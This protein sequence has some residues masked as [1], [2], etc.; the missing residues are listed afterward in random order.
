MISSFFAAAR[1]V[2]KRLVADWL[3]VGAAFITILLA[4]VLLASGP[5]Y[6]DAVTISA[7]QQTIEDAPVTESNLSIEISVFPRFYEIADAVVRANVDRTFAAT[8]ADILTYIDAEAYGL[9]EQASDGVAE[10]AAFKYFESMEDRATL[11]DGVWPGG[12]TEPYQ[13]AVST[14]TARALGLEVGDKLVVTNRRDETNRPEMEV[15]GIFEFDDATD[16]F[17]FGDELVVAGFVQSSSFRTFGPFVVD[18][19]TMLRGLTPV[20]SSAGWRVLPDYSN[21][22]VAEV[23]QLRT[24]VTHLAQELNTEF[25][26]AMG[27]DT[28]G[29]SEFRVDTAMPDL[30]GGVDRSLTV[31]RSSVL[32]LL[33][34]LAILAGYALALTAGLLTDTRRTETALLRSRGA[35][36]GQILTS[37]VLEGLILTVPAVLLA[38]HVASVFLGV[39]NGAGPLSSI[40]LEINPMPIPEAFTLAG[41]AAILSIVALAWPAYRSARRFG[42]SGGRHQRQQSRPT[43]QRIGLDLALV[44]LAVIAFWQLNVLGPEIGARVRGRFGVDPLLIVAPA[45]GLL[46]GAVLALRVVP[47]L[48]RMGEWV[49]S[50]WRSSVP[51]LAAW[52]VARRPTRYARSALLLIMAIAIGLFAAAYST[53]WITSQQDQAS[54]AVGADVTLLP[55][56][57]VANSISDLHLTN[58]HKAVAGVLESMPVQRQ[59]GTLAGSGELGQFLLLDAAKAADV[60]DL[61]EDL[62]ADFD[63][64]MTQLANGRPVLG[65]VPLPG[66]AHTLG[67]HFEAVEELPEPPETED[68][69][70]ETEDPLPVFE[71][72]VRMILQDGDGLLHRVPVGTIPVNEGM[73]RLDLDLSTSLSPGTEVTPTYPLSIVNIEIQSPIPSDFARV[74]ELT[75]GGISVLESNT[76]AKVPIALDWGSWSLATSRVI[77]SAVRPAIA[78]APPPGPG[79]LGMEIQ[80]GLGFGVAP[81]YF[82]LRPSGTTLPETFPVVVSA[83]FLESNLAGVGDEVR[84]PPLGISNDTAVIAGAVMGF[85]TLD[86]A[87]GEM[88]IADLPTVQM[89]GYEPGFGLGRVDEYWLATEGDDEAVMATLRAPPLA[90][91][92]V[93][94]TRETATLLA[95]DPVALGT[96]G[97]LTVGFVAAAIFAS[98]GFAVSATVS[99]RERLVEFALLRALG[100]S[101]R[102]LGRWLTLEQGV[103]VVAGL[104]LGTLVGVVL[105]S[106]I[107]PLISLTQDGAQ[108]I[109]PVVVVYPWRT[110]ITMD[111][112]V[113]AV[114][115]VIVAFMTVLL[116]RTGLGSL[117]RIGDD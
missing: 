14:A 34:Q 82:S 48:A 74:V 92:R 99:A 60:V 8:G 7:L 103:L 45:L 79:L 17:W 29:S 73:G 91:P 50:A 80:T 3:I 84:L 26:S 53:T 44:A 47:L 108:A 89:M 102:Q 41:V 86:P 21:L 33:I 68:G 40:G 23:D 107:L 28:A 117:L 69:E 6:A 94:S 70:M 65:S 49:A 64:L 78:T 59:R 24:G 2:A 105:A 19:D 66:R 42:D 4:T 113:L 57:S 12:S 76:W 95:S 61:R 116:R 58:A 9:G 63:L 25:H 81:V 39:L 36:P 46:A 5:I 88:I 93:A 72:R 100:L 38:P 106:T 16:P 56:L 112:A 67:L 90:S 27:G 114:L 101:P 18:L 22:T 51:A 37:S 31:T 52:Q 30:L 96:I 85:P 1:T 55:N 43:S 115:G 98:L 77:G 35:S 11:V 54:Y 110:I 20:R 10:L 111:L 62:A 97:A 71:G 75:F 104:A 13:T 109:P 15:A 83:T 87:L 32:A